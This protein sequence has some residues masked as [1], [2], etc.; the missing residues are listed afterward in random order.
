MPTGCQLWSFQSYS[1]LN[2]LK[3]KGEGGGGGR[4]L[5]L[6]GRFKNGCKYNHYFMSHLWYNLVLYHT[7]CGLVH[8]SSIIEL[9]L[10]RLFTSPLSPSMHPFVFMKRYATTNNKGN[11]K[12]S[13]GTMYTKRKQINKKGCILLGYW[14]FC[15]PHYYTHRGRNKKTPESLMVVLTELEEIQRTV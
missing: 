4:R 13:L 14:A 2:L 1:A 8:L 15:S 3:R 10:D 5:G 11:E 6:L 7:S 12:C 9:M